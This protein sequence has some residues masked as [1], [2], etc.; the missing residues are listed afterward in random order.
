MASRG[1]CLDSRDQT[2]GIDSSKMPPL[3]EN[4]RLKDFLC[5]LRVPDRMTGVLD[6][7]N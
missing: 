5:L 2:K 7:G 6:S 4:T 3:L 1:G